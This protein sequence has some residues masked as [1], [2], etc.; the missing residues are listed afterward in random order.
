MK[1]I[2]ALAISRQSLAVWMP[3]AAAFALFAALLTGGD[4]GRVQA[5]TETAPPQDNQIHVSV[6][7][8]SI[9]EDWPAEQETDIIVS[10]SVFD[11]DSLYLQ[12]TLQDSEDSDMFEL[13]AHPADDEGYHVFDLK[14]K[15]NQQLD[16]ETQDFY[17]IDALITGEFGPVAEFLIQLTITDLEEPIDCVQRLGNRPQ[18]NNSWDTRCLSD[19]PTAHGS[20][21][22][23]ARFYTFSLEEA[24]DVAITLTSSEDTYLY[25]MQ[26]FGRNKEVVALNDNYRTS[27][28]SR[29]E[30]M[31]LDAGDYTIE[32]TT[33]YGERLGDFVLYVD[34]GTIMPFPTPGT[35]APT[36]TATPEPTPIPTP[37][38]TPDTPESTPQ[39]S[40]EPT[41]TVPLPTPSPECTL[42]IDDYDEIIGIWDD[43]CLSVKPTAHG[44][45]NR[46]ARFYTFTLQEPS[47]VTISL[48]SYRDTFL[49]L[50]S[51]LVR[52][53]EVIAEN[54]NFG[55]SSDSLI[56]IDLDPGEYTI[57]ATTYYAEHGGQFT[58]AI[59]RLVL[60]PEPDVPSECGTGI[61]VA[62]PSTEPNLVA[63]CKVLLKA[64][65]GL[66]GSELLNWSPDI[67]MDYWNGIIIGGP[68]RRVT[69]L[70]LDGMELYGSI[71]V[72]FGEL[73]GLERLSLSGNRFSGEIPPE[74]GDLRNLTELSLSDNLLS[75]QIPIELAKLQELTTLSLSENQLSGGIPSILGSLTD[76]E[77]LQ[78]Q[79][80]ALTGGIPSRIMDLSNLTELR[81]SG[82]FLTGCIHPDLQ[83]V[84]TNDL[85]QLGLL[86]C[87]L[88]VCSTASAVANPDANRD[89]VLDC[90]ALLTARD[91]LEAEQILNWS[92]DIPIE[93][94][95]GVVV[96]GSPRR[97]T[98]LS[99]HNGHLQGRHIPPE[100]GRLAGLTLLRLENN[101][102]TGQIPQELGSLVNLEIL[103][104]SKNELS[105]QIPPAIGKLSELSA[106]NLSDN[107]LSGDIP[108]EIGGLSSLQ[109]LRLDNNEL[110]G[111]IPA[112]MGLLRNLESLYLSNN[113]ISGSIPPEFG[114]L[115]ALETL[116]M[117]YNLLS[118]EI[119]P[120][121]G[122]LT[123]LRT[124]SLSQNRL[125]GEI[126]AQLAAN[127][128]LE[129][130]FL[131][132][133]QFSGCIPTELLRVPVNDLIALGLT[134][135]GEGECSTGTAVADP[136]TNIGL[137]SDCNSLLAALDKIAVSEVA[138]ASLNWSAEVPIENWDGVVIDDSLMRVTELDISGRGMDGVIPPELGSLTNLKALSLSDNQLNGEVPAQLVRLANLEELRL[139]NN[140]LTGEIP[141][142][143][144]RLSNLSKLY[145]AG[146]QLTGC[147]PDE[148]DDVAENDIAMLGLLFCEK[149]FCDSGLAFENPEANPDLVQDCETLLLI[150][151][152]LAGSA[153]LNWS[154]R[155]PIT[156]WDGVTVDVSTNRVVQLD[157]S[158]PMMSQDETEPIILNGE[159][160][161]ALG[162]L[163]ALEVLAL[164]GNEL[165]GQI[166]AE[167]A[168]LSNLKKLLLDDNMLTGFIAYELSVLT[169]LEELRLSGNQFIGCVPSDWRDVPTNDLNQLGLDF[170]ITEQCSNGIVVD[171]PDANPGLVSDCSALL[172][173]RDKIRG[174]VYL[175]W[176]DNTPIQDWYGVI[177]SGTPKRVTELRMSQFGMN[178][179]IPSELG[180]LSKLED[181]YLT[182]NLLAGAIPPELG[183]LSNLEGLYLSRNRLTGAIPQELGSLS[184]LQYLYLQDNRLDGAIPG[185]LGNLTALQTLNLSENELSGS[186]PAELGGLSNL[187]YLYLHYNRLIGAIPPELSNLTALRHLQLTRNRLT[188][189][190]PTELISLVELRTLR[191]SDN[192]LTGNIPPEL[193]S[194][195][196]LAQLYLSKN[197]LTGQ[198]PQEFNNLTGLIDL[199]I[200]GNSLTGCIPENLQGITS[201]LH[202]LNLPFCR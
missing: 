75:G 65:E 190:I 155:V 191:L 21:T 162:S 28:N 31:P 48:T 81:L 168:N 50:M 111:A 95:D 13:V 38:S 150:R 109:T 184:N 126:P 119:P 157:L 33:Y 143:L 24:A 165:S 86:P 79:D 93:N 145:L 197:Q 114:D 27:N 72:E 201:D 180:M 167:L 161:P 3:I 130:L 121:L 91:K 99:I 96:G 137:V 25:L 76:L 115:S 188:G 139:A 134:F 94:W 170:C 47:G 46:Y 133:N 70:N 84:E 57:E 120:E 160:P 178:G 42:S 132:E 97:V 78:L 41:A 195:S 117:E 2:I 153:E 20:T 108:P 5:Q 89:L 12:F 68:Q 49:Y 159:I 179:E 85:S 103:L 82:N 122:S 125:G 15:E 77:T 8:K 54:D 185:I 26:G 140:Q 102:L 182:R 105:G 56:Q 158:Q 141:E 32:A 186:I 113:K 1:H 142:E 176:S 22:R 92:A 55:V 194:L 166:P 63:D 59:E 29:I 4:V 34:I 101:Q 131:R 189:T 36:A 116:M 135:C 58:L 136:N 51:G 53:G 43:T 69:T 16:Y 173:A 61:V 14:L 146:N 71:P 154:A 83:S 44:S 198:I 62:N 169:N 64:K 73:I 163:S 74:L 17:V 19:K 164:S 7:Q 87:L 144:A 10:F 196:K 200:S 193:G 118:G 100:L 88:G 23:Y 98:Q 30:A 174:S 148:L 152:Q 110:G 175:N 172:T 90:E 66:A 60:P 18:M 187:Q 124:L 192:Q 112:E 183:S 171:E 199:Y 106:L 39:P 11:P 123:N 129:N 45:S 138:Q 128:N 6:T 127:P 149:V 67:P 107:Q 35:P 151:D 40:P 52:D 80:N 177:V 156:T 37:T 147:V 9:P 104:L 181:L 202:L